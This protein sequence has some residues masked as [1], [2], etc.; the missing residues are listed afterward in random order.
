MDQ[1]LAP[2]LAP[3]KM[4]WAT[5]TRSIRK[6]KTRIEKIG[7]SC[8]ETEPI[9]WGLDTQ[10]WHL[11]FTVEETM[12]KGILICI[13]AGF[14]SVEDLPRTAIGYISKAY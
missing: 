14:E 3:E 8:V 4:S 9:A 11:L 7:G 2:V 1:K 5:A 10:V 12:H 13:K 6:C